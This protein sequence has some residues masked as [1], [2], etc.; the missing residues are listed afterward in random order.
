MGS[1]I[2]LGHP[3]V[4][5]LTDEIA[6]LGSAT[7]TSVTPPAKRGGGTCHWIGVLEL[8]LQHHVKSRARLCRDVLRQRPRV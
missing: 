4:A 6:C 1:W 2:G 5:N 8:V 7:S 3:Q